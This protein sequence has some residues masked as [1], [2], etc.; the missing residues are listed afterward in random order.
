MG[1]NLINKSANVD[2]AP[3]LK[4]LFI[5]HIYHFYNCDTYLDQSMSYK[6]E[7]HFVQTLNAVISVI[8]FS[9]KI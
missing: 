4:H 8:T 2:D 1:Y 7:N 9:V 3:V 6:H 5:V